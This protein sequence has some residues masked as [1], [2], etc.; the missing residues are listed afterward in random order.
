LCTCYFSCK[1]GL[2]SQSIVVEKC[3]VHK[4]LEYVLVPGKKRSVRKTSANSFSFLVVKQDREGGL[5]N[6][7]VLI[8]L[9]KH[10]A[11]LPLCILARDPDHL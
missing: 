1:S 6:K 4:D 10:L 11:L 8:V 3:F 9:Q 7:S 2:I 5:Q